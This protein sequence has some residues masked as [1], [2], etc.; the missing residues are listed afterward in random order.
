MPGPALNPGEYSSDR[1]E[2][3]KLNQGPLK[4][5]SSL[6]VRIATE[7]VINKEEMGVDEVLGSD[8]GH[9]EKLDHGVVE[10]LC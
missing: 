5:S 7:E 6:L 1:A 9:G 4:R 8:V 3:F 10:I 2:G